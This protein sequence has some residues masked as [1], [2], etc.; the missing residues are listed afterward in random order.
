ANSACSFTGL[1]DAPTY[2]N[3]PT[4]PDFDWYPGVGMTFSLWAYLPQYKDPE[5]LMGRRAGDPFWQVAI[6]SGALQTSEVPLNQWAH[7]VMVLG[8]DT[9]AYYINGALSHV[10]PFPF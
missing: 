5:H 7:I 1:S 6:G 10:D 2:I 4:S 8:T 9:A 3:V